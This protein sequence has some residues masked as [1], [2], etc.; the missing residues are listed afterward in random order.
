MFRP[1]TKFQTAQIPIEITGFRLQN[2][3]EQW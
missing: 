3:P 2:F 1:H